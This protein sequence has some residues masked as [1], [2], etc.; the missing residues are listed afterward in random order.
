MV[1]KVL[2]LFDKD[3]DGVVTLSEFL[4]AGANGLP[5]FK[6]FEELGHHYGQYK[7]PRSG[8]SQTKRAARAKRRR[9]RADLVHLCRCVLPVQMKRASSESQP[10]SNH[11]L[12][13]KMLMC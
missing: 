10:P 9:S 12:P 2:S 1:D 6:G 13:L 4:E 8:R 7:S 3:G 5:D 11:H